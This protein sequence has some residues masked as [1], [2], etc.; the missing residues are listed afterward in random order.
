MMFKA[1]SELLCTLLIDHLM[2]MATHQHTLCKALIETGMVAP[3]GDVL[4][5][6]RIFWV[7]RLTTKVHPFDLVVSVRV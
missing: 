6:I 5:Y 7:L 2:S 1:F 4:L 3:M